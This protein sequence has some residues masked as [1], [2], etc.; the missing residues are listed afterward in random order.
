MSFGGSRLL[1]WK[2][3]PGSSHLI[4]ILGT[5]AFLAPSSSMPAHPPSPQPPT[6]SIK[7]VW[8]TGLLLLTYRG[9]LDPNRQPMGI[10]WVG[11]AGISR[12]SERLGG[13]E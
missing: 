8:V 4:L 11:C 12:D 3:Y 6:P 10:V 13:V 5:R 2:G 7:L 9:L 1:S